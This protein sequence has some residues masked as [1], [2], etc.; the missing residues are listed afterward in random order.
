MKNAQLFI[1]NKNF[2]FTH[3]KQV[4]KLFVNDRDDFSL[5]RSLRFQ[6]VFYNIRR[7]GKILLWRCVASKFENK[8]KI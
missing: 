4:T 8:F 2:N 6:V 1:N 3:K 5:F 7:L